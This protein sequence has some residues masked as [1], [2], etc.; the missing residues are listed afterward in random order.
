VTGAT[1]AI[2]A[3]IARGLAERGFAV[4]LIA[5]DETKAKRGVEALRRRVPAARVSHGLIDLSR[6]ASV[7]DFARRFSGPLDVLVNNAALAPR[8]REQTPE[9]IERQFATNVLGYLWMVEALTDALSS[10][11]GARVVNVASYWA[12][13]LELDDLEFRRRRYDNG[14]AYRQS[15]Q[16]NR[17]LTVL[18]AEQL[19]SFGVNVNACHPG[20]VD[21]A[22]SNSLGFG[23]HATP[24]E[25][26]A[27]PIWLATS[28]E[29]A[30]V[31]SRY[32]EQRREVRCRFAEDR[33]GVEKLY[34]ACQQRS[35]SASLS[36]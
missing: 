31:T 18:Q 21:S 12:G 13:D 1:G 23:G 15:K 22:L 2:G 14:T 27:T 29:I 4:V 36:E 10:A 30:D 35:H 33:L 28:A 20:D 11:A 9:G 19:A 25:G 32:F 24:D 17:M 34:E 8:R 26:A 6:R 7:V 5:R 16:A 3:A